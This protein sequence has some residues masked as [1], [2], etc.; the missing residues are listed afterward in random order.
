MSTAMTKN[1]PPQIKRPL[2]VDVMEVMQ[3]IE[4]F[5]ALLLRE[6]AAL[7]KADFSVVDTLQP[8][9][10]TLALQYQN[11]VT[12]LAARKAEMATLDVAA[13]E[14][15]VKARTQFTLILND[16]LRAL[17]AAKDSTRRL[18]SKILDAAR[19]TV[20]DEKQTNY[21]AKGHTQAYKTSTLSLSVD[22]K[23]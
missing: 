18:V 13:R 6:T 2:A 10:R 8:A 12:S 15:L 16:N 19:K 20:V 14:R 7:K 3:L 17:E 1:A 5:G 21:S 11:M 22:Q 4:D 9:K 23:L